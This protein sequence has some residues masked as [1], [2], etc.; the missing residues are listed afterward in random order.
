V[1]PLSEASGLRG[2]ILR[3]IGWKA[4]SQIGGLALAMVSTFALAHLLTPHEYGLGVA[5][6]VFGSLAALLSDLG[7]GSSLVQRP[8]LTEEH[9]STAFWTSAGVGA[10]LMLAGV[11]FAE[12]V[13]AAYRQPGV[14]PLLA[15]FSL[16]F[17]LSALGS[18][19]GSLLVRELRFRS[20]EVRTL[21]S[22]VVA[23]ATGITLA[24]LGAGAWALVVQGLAGTATSTILL[25][26]SS[27]WRP[28][29]IYSRESFRDLRGVSG[30]VL[31]TNL[32]FYVNRNAD[33]VII[34]RFRGAAALG[35]YAIAYNAM[36]VPLT[37]LVSPVQQVLFP[38]MSR[39]REPA[40]MGALW[41]RA[42]RATSALTIPAFVGLAVVAP[43]F[44]P[45]VLS[46]QWNAAVP[47]LQVLAWVGILQA[48]VWQTRSVLTA[49]GHVRALLWFALV[50]A[51]CTVA[52]FAIGVTQGVVGVAV[53]FA[54]VSSVLE[55]VYLG[56]GLRATGVTFRRFLGALAGVAAAAVLMGA[57]VFGVRQLLL[58][59]VSTAPR[60][61]LCILVGGL[62]YVPLAG[63]L[64]P[65][66][67]T[68]LLDLRRRRREPTD[69]R[70]RG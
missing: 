52:A 68:E 3:G 8:E 29:F 49:L 5:A 1:A 70:A 58:G 42:T 23:V 31:G 43:D 62:V 21:V 51:V 40:A 20:L 6:L 61:V 2:L 15:V 48:V 44:V 60:L 46:E 17:L 38:A 33:N 67:R 69:G 22:A 50:S 55:P 4:A 16:N 37:R 45:V 28:R 57:A 36:L 56:L 10:G 59:H 47:V 9:K 26:A 7:L 24:A 64:A 54:L 27:S 19:Q 34:S 18:T 66:L 32:L 25:W 63:L 65:A 11:A 12:P 53:A 39:I 13:A 30:A 35:V 14:A 41:V